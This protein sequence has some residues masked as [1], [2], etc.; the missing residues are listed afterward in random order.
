MNAT[1]IPAP[2]REL[3]PRVHA[4][5]LAGVGDRAPTTMRIPNAN[6]TDPRIA[7]AEL[8]T[9]FSAPLLVTPSGAI[10]EPGSFL[11][12]DL[13][14]TP[15]IVSR[16]GDG[17][18]RVLVNACRH[19]GAT[20][21][22]GSGCTRRFTCP[23]HGWS[24]DSDGSLVGVPDRRKGFDDPATRGL[25]EPPSEER[26]GFVWAVRDP[27]GV[28]DVHR[29]LGPLDAELARWDYEHHDVVATMEVK[30]EA[31]WKCALEA[32]QE[33]YHFPYV[34]AQSL[35]G[36]GTVANIVT[37]DQ[38]GR[39]HRLGVPLKMLGAE[40]E[41]LPGENITC[42]YCIHPCSVI[43]TSPLGGELLRFYPGPTPASSTI[44]HTVLSRFPLAD[45]AVAAFF[46]DYTPQIQAV[47]RDEDAVVL[48][49]S[50]TGI[51]AGCSA[52]LAD[53]PRRDMDDK[54]GS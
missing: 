2:I 53:A 20:V 48:E 30:V 7:A 50:G 49:R 44:R 21:A 42:I 5:V 46:K 4:A 39:H 17:R 38:F 25:V 29:Q 27:H 23:Y 36:H 41:P 33:T 3:T 28:I 47:V 26:N 16:G 40:P 8:R 10:R 6:Y 15:V 32:F 43:A 19:R 31:N 18:A 14:G 51:A 37:F 52:D 1:A 35:V 45:D 24:Y 22:E 9:A 12:F 54:G 11:T 13:M 34:H